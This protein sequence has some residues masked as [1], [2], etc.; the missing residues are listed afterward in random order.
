[1][2]KTYL[3]PQCQ[4][5]LEHMERAGSITMREAIMDH[6]IQSLTRRITDLRDMGYR[7]ASEHKNHPITGQ[8]YVRYVLR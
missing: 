3:S 7:I 2:K 6:S 4:T 8:R 1:M 5:V